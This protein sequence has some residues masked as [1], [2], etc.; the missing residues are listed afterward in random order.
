LFDFSIPNWGFFVGEISQCLAPKKT[1]ASSTKDLFWKK[2]F[3]THHIFKGEKKTK[4]TI[5][6]S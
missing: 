5:F 1:I 2:I 4:I 3:E 6:R